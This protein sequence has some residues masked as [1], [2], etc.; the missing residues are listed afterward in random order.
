MLKFTP[1]DK[2]LEILKPYINKFKMRLADETLG[3]RYIWGQYSKTEYAVFNDT[4]ILK[5]Q[6]EK[7]GVFF[8]Y[9]IGEDENG[10]FAEIENYAIENYLPL[11]FIS[12]SDEYVDDFN[13]RYQKIESEF[14]RDYADYVYPVQN[15]LGYKGKALS[16]QRNHL[17]K[18]NKL[19]PNHSIENITKEN[20]ESVKSFLKDFEQSVVKTNFTA[21]D[22]YKTIYDF[23]DNM[24]EL[25]CFGCIL[26]VD[27][28]IVGF[29]VGEIVEDTLYVHIEK[30]DRSFNGAYP[31]L[32]CS[33]ATKFYH[34]NIEFI[35]REDDSGD[36]GLRTSKLQ[37]KPCEIRAKNIVRVLTLFDKIPTEFVVET[38]RLTLT[39]LKKEDKELYCKLNLDDGLNKWWGYDYK[40]DLKGQIP[41]GEYF[42][43]FQNFLKERKEEFC[44]TV[45][46]HGKLIGELPLHHFDHHGG[47][48]IGFRFFKEYQGKGYAVESANALIEFVKEVAGAKYIKSRC[49]K[50]NLPSKNL[51]TKLGLQLVKEDK[52]HY[53]FRKDF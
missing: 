51:I 50:Q 45:K 28:N 3:T 38:D 10:A 11:Q 23:L 2:N 48:E 40:D 7:G 15:F 35:N 6:F 18:F 31:K 52:T 1:L 46:L 41:T 29:S 4:L 39:E 21:K 32:A 26:K 36:L 14:N 43:N 8:R 33:F 9:P 30:A 47:I 22:E 42:F 20:I 53:Y 13:K 24:F 16:G 44:V 27:E 5:E 49:F 37:Y 25:N 17:N 12:I 19:Y 34:D